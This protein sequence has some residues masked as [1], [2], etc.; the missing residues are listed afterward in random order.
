M[1]KKNTD[2]ATMPIRDLIASMRVQA[3]ELPSSDM[4]RM[5]FISIMCNRLE[6]QTNRA[7]KAEKEVEKITKKYNFI[8]SLRRK[9]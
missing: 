7:D 8:N 3:A 9:T 2:L 5:L 4:I 6:E 1:D